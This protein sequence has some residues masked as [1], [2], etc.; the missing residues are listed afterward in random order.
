[1]GDGAGRCHRGA[2]RNGSSN[3]HQV[4]LPAHENLLCRATTPWCQP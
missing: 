3:R 2:K 4:H 1:M